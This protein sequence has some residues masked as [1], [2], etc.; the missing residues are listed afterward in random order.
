MILSPHPNAVAGSATLQ[1]IRTARTIMNRRRIN[2]SR[3]RIPVHHSPQSDQSAPSLSLGAPRRELA[4]LLPVWPHE[5]DDTTRAGAMRLVAK[6]RSALRAERQRGLRGHWA[7]DLARHAALLAA[8]RAER[9]KL[10]KDL[11]RRR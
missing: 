2:G 6:L 5:R 9:D 4:Y 1:T 3:T 8:Y 10:A 7:Y 11:T